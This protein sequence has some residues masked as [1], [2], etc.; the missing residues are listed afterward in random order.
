MSG[1]V[2]GNLECYVIGKRVFIDFIKPFVDSLF[3]LFLNGKF[4]QYI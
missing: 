2:S 1:Y 4:S 3:D